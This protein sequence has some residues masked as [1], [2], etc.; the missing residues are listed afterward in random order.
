MDNR[1]IIL[2][3]VTVLDD[4]RQLHTPVCIYNRH[5]LLLYTFSMQI[6]HEDFDFHKYKD[7]VQA[8]MVRE[9]LML[10]PPRFKIEYSSKFVNATLRTTFTIKVKDC[11]GGFSV[12][13]EFLFQIGDI[14]ESFKCK[15]YKFT[16]FGRKFFQKRW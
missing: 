15:S 13:G 14:G 5:A 9:S 2:E 3:N 11:D 6:N 10:Y 8:L 16:G 12:M 4:A 1:S 7:N